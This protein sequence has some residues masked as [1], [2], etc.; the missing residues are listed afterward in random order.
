MIDRSSLASNRQDLIGSTCAVCQRATIQQG[1]KFFPWTSDFLVC[2]ACSTEFHRTGEKFVLRKIPRNYERWLRFGR[3][4]LSREEIQRI[5]GGGKSDAEIAAAKAAQDA[6]IAKAA[7]AAAAAKAAR[8]ELLR[9]SQIEGTPEYY[10]VRFMNILGLPLDGSHNEMSFTASS[11][12]EAK[13]QVAR[14]KQIQNEVKFLKKE[15][16]PVVSQR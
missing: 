1:N 9:K 2:P 14:V 5:A 11:K 13:Q 7:Q 12:S 3:Q 16:N 4:A 6:E 8:E 10:Y 15:I